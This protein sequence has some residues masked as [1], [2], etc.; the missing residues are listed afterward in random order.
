M[1]AAIPSRSWNAI[2]GTPPA[3]VQRSRSIR[4][5][6]RARS[7]RR[8]ITRRPPRKRFGTRVAKQPVTWNSGI[9]SRPTFWGADGSGTGTGSPRRRKARA[10]ENGWAITLLAP[11]RWVPIAPLERPVVPE[12]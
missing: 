12:V 8:I 1:P 10:A 11:A 4:A 7:Q 5:I 6:A 2:V 9:E 3:L